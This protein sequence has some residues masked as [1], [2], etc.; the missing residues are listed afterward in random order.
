MR[1]HI[2]FLSILLL[3]NF[4]SYSQK[5]ITS[6]QI[7]H[8]IEKLNTLGTVL[9]LAAHPD[10]ENTRLISYFA[11]HHHLDTYYLSLTRGDGGQNL[12]GTETG[13]LL[14]ILRTQELLSARRIDNGGQRF[15]RALDFGYSKTADETIRIWDEDKVKHDIIWTVRNLKPDIIINR[16][17]HE[18]NGKTHGHHT[19]SAM[20]SYELF[21]KYGDSNS[22]PE[23][24]N[25]VSTWQPST[26]YFNTSWWFYGGKDK[27]KAADKSD[28]IG[29]DI[30]SYYPSLGYSNN[31]IA[32]LSRSQHKCQGFGSTGSRGTHIEYLK[33][34]KGSRASSKMDVTQG[35]DFSWSRIKNGQQI[36]DKIKTIL[37]SFDLKKPEASIPSLIEVAKLIEKIEDNHW[38]SKKKNEVDEIISDC[39]GLYASFITDR[40]NATR[41]EQVNCSVELTKRLPYPLYLNSFAIN[42]ISQELSQEKIEDNISFNR[43]VKIGINKSM[44]YTSPYWLQKTPSLGVYN[45]DS[46]TLIGLPNTKAPYSVKFN[47]EVDGYSFTVERELQYRSNHPEKGEVNERFNILPKATM[48]FKNNVY[49]FSNTKSK[50]IIVEVFTHK[51]SLNG[52]LKLQINN[53]WKVTPAEQNISLIG[54]GQ[55]KLIEFEVIPPNHMETA[56]AHI[57]M[58]VEGELFQKKLVKIEY[59]HIDNQQVLS[60][61]MATFVSIPMNTYG[62]NI[63]YIQGA[64]DKIPESLRQIGYDVSELT[65]DQLTSDKLKKFDAV[66]LGV[67]AYNK[68]QNL[69]YKQSV[70]F[71]YVKNGG[72][73][74]TQYNTHRNLASKQIGPYPFE[75]SRKRVSVEEAPITITNPSHPI[76]NYPN[77]ISS[78]DFDNWVQERGLYFTINWSEEY[79]TLVSTHDPREDPLHSAILTTS[80]GKGKFIYTSLSLFRQLPAGVPGAFKLIANMISWGNERP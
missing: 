47:L 65:V 60:P 25:Y 77:Q 48:D 27:F 18:S 50:K 72:T 71:D 66:L 80:Y 61:A 57:S 1:L 54:K 38:R 21:D 11:N 43:E 13:P 79:E 42:N 10:D 62:H 46:L 69:K 31:E 9:Y 3:T 40:P 32:A 30:G 53:G 17:D 2:F 55:S 41:G 36:G 76:L 7:Y 49:I 4:N 33:Y 64:G 63:A 12:I 68:H 35:F 28:L 58:E 52:L 70:L 74:I 6:S 73:L 14:G 34:L 8:K 45:V 39:L 23:Q 59:D 56:M 5:N 51:D 29:V 37:N 26:L 78:T 44:E 16:F 22:F 20:L 19:A 67:R 24:L 75:I 15:T